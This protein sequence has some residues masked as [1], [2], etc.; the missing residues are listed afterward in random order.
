M[1]AR[2]QAWM[3][4]LE[5]LS[6]RER[7][8]ILVAIFVMAY[9]LGDLVILDRQYRRVEQLN[10]EMAQDHANIRRLSGELTALATQVQ[11]DPNRGLRTDI[12]Q[13]RDYIRRQQ[14][15]LKALTDEM[16]S[17]Q[18]MARFLEELL[19]R[20]Q[21]LSLLRLQTL[22]AEPLLPA[23][24]EAGDVAATGPALH[25]HGFEIEF[26]GGYMATLH[27]LEALEG[28]PWR[29]FWDS[30]DYEVTD[31]PSSVVRLKLHTLS[32]SEDWIGV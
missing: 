7:V 11:A 19:V 4:R 1:Q 21:Q 17:P 12:G 22:G 13:A 23:T 28:L 26:A 8:L 3:A 32:F 30:V 27:Y 2:W 16:I 5:A 6:A 31:Y 9:Q 25:R 20:D 29:F 15:R 10:Q 14:E 24:T 18:D